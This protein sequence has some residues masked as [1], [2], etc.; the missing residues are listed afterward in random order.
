MENTN[1]EIREIFGKKFKVVK[2]SCTCIC[3]RDNNVMDITHIQACCHNGLA[4]HFEE[5][6]EE[7][8]K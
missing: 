8:K 6:K 5:I 2:I 4:E 1:I 3:H 7:P